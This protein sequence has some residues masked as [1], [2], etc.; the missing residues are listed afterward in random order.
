[1]K[2]ANEVIDQENSESTQTKNHKNETYLEKYGSFQVGV[3]K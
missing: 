2:M 1:M 3:A